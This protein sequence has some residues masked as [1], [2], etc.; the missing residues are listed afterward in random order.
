MPDPC[1]VHG[2]EGCE[3]FICRHRPRPLRM[4]EY[5]GSYSADDTAPDDADW[6]SSS[7][8][9]SGSSSSPDSGSSSCD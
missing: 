5:T 3:A 6:G 8:S 7:G 4:T 9:D 2:K 1:T